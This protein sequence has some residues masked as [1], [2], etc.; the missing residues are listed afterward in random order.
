[1]QEKT[2]INALLK[3][4]Q[5]ARRDGSP[6]LAHVDAI[7]TE[8]GFDLASLSQK[9]P[10]PANTLPRGAIKLLLLSEMRDGPKTMRQL[11]DVA[12]VTWPHLRPETA[13]R[14]VG[15]ALANHKR[16]GM[17]AREGRLWRLAQ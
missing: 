5:D 6:T 12:E 14:R 16:K 15:L 17:V 11:V 9:P 13:Y 8:R 1:M 2:I 3:I 10:M 7:L 4:R